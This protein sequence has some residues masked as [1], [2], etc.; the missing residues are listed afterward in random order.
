MDITTPMTTVG[1]PSRSARTPRSDP[2][3]PFPSINNANPRNNGSTDAT[4]PRLLTFLAP[5][6]VPP[7]C[8]SRGSRGLV[9]GLLTV[10]VVPFDEWYVSEGGVEPSGVMAVD[11]GEDRP[12]DPG[13]VL[14]WVAA[15]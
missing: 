10:G 12:A 4:T 7:D 9:G 8:R 14:E 15:D 2:S 11:P 13:T 1:K 3:R 6:E 5:S